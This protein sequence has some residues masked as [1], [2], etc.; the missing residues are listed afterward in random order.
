MTDLTFCVLGMA[1]GPVTMPSFAAAVAAA[2]SGPVACLGERESGL[3]AAALSRFSARAGDRL[4]VLVPSRSPPLD[5]A[6]ND[7][8]V[9]AFVAAGQWLGRFAQTSAG[10]PPQ[11][12]C[13]EAL[14]LATSAQGRDIAIDIVHRETPRSAPSANDC[15]VEAI[16]PHRG[17]DDHLLASV[18]SLIGQTSRPLITVCF[19]QRPEVRTVRKLQEMPHVRGFAI[20]PTEAGP[21]VIR[22]HFGLTSDAELIAF[23]DSDDYALPDRI[24]SMASR[25]LSLDVDMLGCHELRLDEIEGIVQAIRFPLDVSAALARIASHPQLFPTTLV[26]A[27]AFRRCGG[28]STL[29]RFGSDLQ[30]L[31]RAHFSMRIGNVDEF[32]YV[33]RRR[34]NSLTT[35]PETALHTPVR[36]E[37]DRR[38]KEDFAAVKSGGLRLEHSAIGLHHT[39]IPYR[40]EDLHSGRQEPVVQHRSSACEPR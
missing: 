29:R 23:Q 22:Q 14:R 2:G 34:S 19:D 1:G 40:I 8:E 25:L 3:A 7:G 28:L 37:F 10:V 39:D 9:T 21:Y 36:L 31:L 4:T 5:G 26:R 15:S 13:Y 17:S 33:R 35:S 16:V 12:L 20:T 18:A 32:L 24:R 30:F 6:R 11:R 27:S 38:W